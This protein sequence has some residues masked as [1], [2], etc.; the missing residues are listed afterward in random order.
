MLHP[1]TSAPA[2]DPGAPARVSFRVALVVCGACVAALQRGLALP[3]HDALDVWL[4]FRLLA[5]LWGRMCVIDLATHELDGTLIALTSDHGYRRRSTRGE[6]YAY[7]L[8]LWF[9]STRFGAFIALTFAGLSC[10]GCDGGGTPHATDAGAGG[11]GS[12]LSI[13][14]AVPNCTDASAKQV[15]SALVEGGA[16]ASG[17]SV[18]F[19]RDVAPILAARCSGEICHQAT[20]GGQGAYATLVDVRTSE[21][22]D[23]RK[24]VAP[25]DPAHSYVMQ[26]LRGLDLCA[27]KPMPLSGTITAAE[28]STIEGWICEGAPN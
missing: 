16:C 14:A 9:Y 22:C 17:P 7:H 11:P 28:V 25:G 21:C 5:T 2:R 13:G 4:G 10:S 24:L 12:V 8:P 1:S 26:K 6:G 3:G 15:G 23:G 18:S 27:G 19:L 20:W